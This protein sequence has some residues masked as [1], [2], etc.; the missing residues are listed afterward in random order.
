[1]SEAI[2]AQRLLPHARALIAAS[3]AALAALAGDDRG[4]IR[5]GAV[6][7]VSSHI[8]PRALA[9]F[10]PSTT[11]SGRSKACSIVQLAQ[12][13]GREG[14]ALVSRGGSP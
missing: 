11:S 10:R 4:V 1:V 2:A 5:L 9:T 3:E 8:L 13:A 14:Q 7:S 12:H 6:E